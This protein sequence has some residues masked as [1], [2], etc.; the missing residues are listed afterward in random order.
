M[1]QVEIEKLI[2]ENGFKLENKEGHITY[3]FGTG[4]IYR[5]S[6]LLFKKMDY[7]PCCETVK[8]KE[9]TTIE[10]N[11][12]TKESAYKRCNEITK[13]LKSPSRIFLYDGENYIELKS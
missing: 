8:D 3:E 7:I 2:L 9:A 4:D 10:V 13:V 12:N 1:T 11:L 5:I 6:Q